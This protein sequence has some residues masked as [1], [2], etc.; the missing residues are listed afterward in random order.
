MGKMKKRKVFVPNAGPRL[1]SEHSFHSK[2]ELYLGRQRPAN[3]CEIWSVVTQ[4]VYSVY[5]TRSHCQLRWVHECIASSRNVNELPMKLL[6]CPRSNGLEAF[7]GPYF[8]VDS[9][10]HKPV[11]D[12]C[13]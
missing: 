2:T 6:R 5:E 1:L 11:H 7:I 8:R 12:R 13:L 3:V 9:A 10:V 4:S